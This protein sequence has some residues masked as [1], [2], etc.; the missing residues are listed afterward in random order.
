MTFA[1]VKFVD[2]RRWHPMFRFPRGE[3]T[4]KFIDV[5]VKLSRL[6]KY[7]AGERE[8][9]KYRYFHGRL[10]TSIASA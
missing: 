1:K 3:L 4:V 8:A 6:M 10:A 9:G 7:V 5:S 2:V